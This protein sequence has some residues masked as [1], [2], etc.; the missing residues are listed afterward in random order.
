[1]TL[2]NMMFMTLPSLSRDLGYYCQ[3]I[4][5]GLYYLVITHSRQGLFLEYCVHNIDRKCVCNSL[6]TLLVN[7]VHVLLCMLNRRFCTSL[8]VFFGAEGTVTTQSNKIGNETYN[9][10]DLMKF[11]QFLSIASVSWTIVVIRFIRDVIAVVS[12]VATW[13]HYVYI[14]YRMNTML[15]TILPVS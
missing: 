5:H 6:A 12:S 3:P 8:V 4:D 11:G 7:D 15:P 13:L 1:M 9:V 14:V 10:L 2:C